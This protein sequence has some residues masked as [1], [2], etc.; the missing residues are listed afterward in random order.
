MILF[1][2]MNLESGISWI[3]LVRLMQKSIN[4]SAFSQK[5]E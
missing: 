1:S 4:N 3:M 5:R 2:E